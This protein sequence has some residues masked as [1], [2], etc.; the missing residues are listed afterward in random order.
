MM[1]QTLVDRCGVIHCLTLE[2]CEE[3]GCGSCDI[4][5]RK[6]SF[7]FSKTA[8]ITNMLI[9]I[10]YSASGGWALCLCSLPRNLCTSI[11]NERVYGRRLDCT[12]YMAEFVEICES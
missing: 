2:R 9:R 7:N 6:V 4:N 3:A 8:G 5:K 10:D 1:D 11:L 12:I